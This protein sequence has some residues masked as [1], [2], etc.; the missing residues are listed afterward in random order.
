MES[1]NYS[2]RQGYLSCEQKRG[3]IQL[4]PKKD[5]DPTY[6]K[7][8]RPISLLNVDT[9][10]LTHTLAQRFQ[11]VLPEII[12]NDQNGFIKK[13]FIGCNIRAIIDVIDYLNREKKEGILAIIDFEKTF[14]KL[15]WKFIDKCLETFN[16]GNG[17]RHWVQV[18][19][20]KIESC[21]INNGY[22]SKYFE[23]ANGVRQGDPLS[24][25][26]FIIG[27]EILAVNIRA[28]KAI[29][30]IT[31]NG[32]ETKIG[33]L[34]DDTTLILQDIISLRNALNVVILFYL[35]SGLKINIDKSEIL[36]VGKISIDFTIKK[37]YQLKWANGDIKSLGIRYFNDVNKINETNL[38]DKLKEFQNVLNKWSKHQI[39]ICGKICIIKN[40]A[41]PK[42][43]YV[44]N[45]LWI[46][47]W[48]ID[49]IVLSLD[50][51][52]WGNKRRWIQK[53]VL[54]QD[55][56]DGGLRNLDY[57][58]FMIAQKI[59]WVKRFVQNSSTLSMKFLSEY[60]PK[61][62]IAFTLSLTLDSNRL[63]KNIP[64]FYQQVLDYWYNVQREPTNLQDIRNQH[65]W[66]NKYIK[67]DG[68]SLFISE[69]S[70]KHINIVNDLLDKDSI[71][72]KAIEIKN[73]FE[74]SINIMTINSLLSAI[75][76]KWKKVIKANK[77]IP[78]I[79][80]STP[81]IMMTSY[82]KTVYNIESNRIYWS[83]VRKKLKPPSCISRWGDENIELSSK[84]WTE[85]F[86][87]TKTIT[88]VIKHRLL[89]FKIMHKN[90]ASDKIVSKFDKT[91]SPKCD[92]CNVD[93][94]IVHIFC[95]CENVKLFWN[96]LENWIKNNIVSDFILNNRM[97]LLGCLKEDLSREMMFKVEYLLLQAR[98]YIH[99]CNIKKESVYFIIFLNVL[100]RNVD[101]EL[102][103]Y[104]VK[105]IK[106]NDLSFLLDLL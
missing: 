55:F 45:V 50:L 72:K 36:Q 8:W 12:N 87:K 48:F 59:A 10:I 80:L 51:F 47:Q 82:E 6:L 39:T 64:V 93:R 29:T 61:H 49:E 46:P 65:L 70:Q 26:L 28:N 15:N 54:I 33:L 7:N 102:R 79:Q 75:P 13:R 27:V 103:F 57:L 30:G 95:N 66:Y 68:H 92:L 98:L 31:I 69:M 25:L 105:C 53:D 32:L 106:Y 2:F 58:S 4:I 19:Y 18:I 101:I 96:L 11:S 78:F 90:Y 62:D 76:R 20:N 63:S 38:H 84:N 71:F 89:N 16:F 37:P 5:K 86:M 97:K 100:K 83:L 81:S 94:D 73:T 1:Y 60:I 21:V 22:T 56:K 88:K 67:V 104:N 43:I 52:L 99:N 41:L 34:A 40:L 91:V 74:L 23:I 3:V 9:K 17:I 44:T 24:A 42:I 77:N 85:I 14:D 35:I